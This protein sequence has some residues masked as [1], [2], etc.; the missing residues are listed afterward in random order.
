MS[1]DAN[2]SFGSRYSSR[3]TFPP[4]VHEQAS[5]KVPHPPQAKVEPSATH[6][7][8]SNSNVGYG[9]IAAP[10]AS[11]LAG[12]AAH[13]EA[14]PSVFQRA[15]HQVQRTVAD[16]VT[17]LRL[18]GHLSVL[19]VAATILFLSQVKIPD[20]NLSLNDLP[21]SVLNASGNGSQSVLSAS[22]PL[23]QSRYA[24]VSETWEALAK[25]ALP[26]SLT[27]EK[28]PEKLVA[29]NQIRP[30]IEV[31]SVQAGDTVL[32]IA[33]KFGLQPETLLWANNA[34]EQNPD[35]LSIGDELNILPV[36]GVLHIVHAG[37]TL[38]TLATKYKVATDSIAG[39]AD[40]QLA[41]SS[42][43]LK[44][45]AQL[46]IPG[47]T[48]PFIL[49]TVVGGTQLYT[50]PAPGNALKGS[51]SFS[52]PTAGSITQRYWSGHP[53]VDIGSWTGA[54]VSASDNG[55]VIE[56]GWGWSSGYGNHVIID[57]GNG[58]STLYAHLSSVYVKVGENVTR[59]EQIGA[60]GNTGNSTGP[61]LHFEVRYQGVPRNPTGYLP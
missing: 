61:H 3:K 51:G 56:V 21:S 33:G 34:I 52:W 35:R 16:Q 30:R 53:A 42:A 12:S 44:I 31:Y 14:L 47:G 24:S 49:P 4:L 50:S 38:S 45:G 13:Q 46:V 6:S 32:A 17:P 8:V 25:H 41:N 23:A 39:Y 2:S 9:A 5:Y 1:V 54:P 15:Q 55:Y 22:G 36:N 19:V 28:S 11:L 40:N 48:K 26:F 57:H 18:A 60:A 29:S 10:Y 27:T 7:P 59:G 37:D 43:Q 20:W 58:F